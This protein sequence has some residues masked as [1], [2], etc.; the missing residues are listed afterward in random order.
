MLVKLVHNEQVVPTTHQQLFPA[1]RDNH[2]LLDTQHN[3]Q[4][5]PLPVR[6]RAKSH[7]FPDLYRFI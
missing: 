1:N 2:N 4:D 7:R 3:V 5:S 6:H